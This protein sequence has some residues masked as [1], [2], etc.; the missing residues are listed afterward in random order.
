VRVDGRL[1]LHLPAVSPA[2]GAV[3]GLRLRKSALE[4]AIAERH[5]QARAAGT[6]A[7][8]RML[9]QELRQVKARLEATI[10]QNENQKGTR[11]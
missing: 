9:G 4:S 10:P 3:A 1:A 6:T 8:V 7:D 2:P 11:T 5:R